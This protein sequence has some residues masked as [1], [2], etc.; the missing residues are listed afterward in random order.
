MDVEISLSLVHLEE[1]SNFLVSDFYETTSTRTL[2]KRST[3]LSLTHIR[4]NLPKKNYNQQ[5]VDNAIFIRFDNII[6]Y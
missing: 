3:F 1:K 5:N 2:S 4:R 6:S